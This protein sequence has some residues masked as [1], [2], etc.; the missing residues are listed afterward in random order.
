VKI[1]SLCFERTGALVLSR[2]PKPEDSLQDVKKNAGETASETLF[3]EY[4]EPIKHRIYNFILK[5]LGFSQ[6]AD[7]VY[8]DTV[9]HAFQYFRTFKKDKD[10]VIWIYSIARNEIKKHYKKASRTA[11]SLDAA[12][13]PSPDASH[14]HQLARE[15]YR[16]ANNLGLRQREV[17]FLFYDS[18]FTIAEISRVTGLREGNIKFI[19]NQARQNLRSIM[20]EKNG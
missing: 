9:L 3:W 17:F 11:G 16:F 15:I 12:L 1:N 5:S 14:I 20:G 10:F 7:D 2:P 18:G 13:L 6:D 8:Q 4:L 19:L